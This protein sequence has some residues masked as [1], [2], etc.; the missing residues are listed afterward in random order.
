M[1]RN[2]RRDN[3]S[4]FDFSGQF[5]GYDRRLKIQTPQNVI[6]V[7]FSASCTMYLTPTITGRD[8][9]VVDESILKCVQEMVR[10]LDDI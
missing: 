2:G 6:Y 10:H 5:G 9:L 7:E 8:L 3:Q 4:Y 1:T